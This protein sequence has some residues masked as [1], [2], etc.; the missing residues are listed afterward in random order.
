MA[1]Q[2]SLDRTFD[3][4]VDDPSLLPVGRPQVNEATALALVTIE[5]I[6]DSRVRNV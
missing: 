2:V 5:G 6:V 3:L 1:E 4:G